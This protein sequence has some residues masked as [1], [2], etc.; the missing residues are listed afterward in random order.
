[1]TKYA[2]SESESS[3]GSIVTNTDRRYSG[4]EEV[5]LLLLGNLLLNVDPISLQQ[6]S[7]LF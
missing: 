2:I 1:M 5:F 4:V 7:N 3:L 6:F